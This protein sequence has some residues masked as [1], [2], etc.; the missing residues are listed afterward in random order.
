M[1][2]QAG[3]VPTDQPTTL[4]IADGDRVR[5]FDYRQALDFHQGNS[6]WGCALAFRMLQ[7]AA[8]L[9]S[10]GRLWD[11]NRLQVVSG[12]PGPGVRDTLELVT[13]CVSGGRF[14]LDG[15][16]REARC[17][18]DMAYRWR[19]IE[20]TTELTLQLAD[21]IVPVGF[22]QLLDK[23]PATDTD[24]QRLEAYKRAMTE[25][26]WRMSLE[27]AFPEKDLKTKVF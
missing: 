5:R 24:M 17:V 22:L 26:I 7:R 11:R 19:L 20:D 3:L 18:G 23:P 12:H 16:P 8:P 27:A 21:G 15:G 10:R 2:E 13:G 25:A 4:E 14:S 1:T 6:Y 9:L